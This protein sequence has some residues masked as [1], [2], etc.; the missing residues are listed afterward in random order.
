M[1]FRD[2]RVWD[3]SG[4]TP[5]AAD[6]LIEGERIRTVAK[7]RGQLDAAGAEVVEAGGMTLMPGLVEGHAHLS[8]GNAVQTTDLGDLPPEEHTLLTAR[9]AKTLL[10]S[11]F[12]SAY[13]AAAAKLRLDVVIRNAI[14]AGEIPG[15]RLKACGPEITVTGG[16][17]DERSHHMYRESF[18]VIADGPHE[19]VKWARLCCREGADSI[20]LNISGDDFYKAAKGE[21]TVM[22][23]AEIRAG[24]EVARDFQRKVNAHCR[25]SESVKRAVRG[26]VDVIYHC[27]H[28]DTEA[29]DLLEAAKDRVFVGPAIGLPYT[30]RESVTALN[31]DADPKVRA[32]VERSF[33]AAVRTYE[34]MR[35]RGIRVVIGGDYGFDM[36]PQ[37]SNARDIKHFVKLFG[38]SA[39]EALVCAT[40]VGAELM[41]MGSEL[42]LVREGFLAD[43]VL[44][45]GDPLADVAILQRADRLAGILQNG[46]V[47]KLDRAAL[48]RRQ[49][50]A[51]E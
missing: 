41:D 49:A 26:G 30:V 6:V 47:H 15:P 7:A 36:T 1:L 19:I 35:K 23:E 25:A 21:M 5:F 28:A 14:Q 48:A 16:L 11:G 39:A 9:N 29:L 22:S 8:F 17:G 42:G 13:S 44:V 12:T 38:Y 4:A 31:A 18:A 46:N 37:G 10:D 24:V 3:G 40:R 32:L 2:C 27:E 33:E 43:L 20:K 45:D 50:R 51:A 34:Q